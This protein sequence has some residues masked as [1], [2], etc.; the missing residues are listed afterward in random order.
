MSSPT[1][2]GASSIVNH[3][4]DIAKFLVDAFAEADSPGVDVSDPVTMRSG[5][6]YMSAEDF[7]LA[8]NPQLPQLLTKHVEKSEPLLTEDPRYSVLPIRHADM[9][10]VYERHLA[11]FWTA[12]EIVY[13]DD[14]P[15]WENKLTDDERFFI[16][17]ILAFFSQSDG[18]VIENLCVRFMAEV[19]PFE[20]KCY[21]GVQ[22]MVETIHS[23]VYALL[24]DTFIKD[25][26][27]KE[28][29]L[30]AI[31]TIPCVQDKGN[32]ALKWISDDAPF[33]KRLIA[34][35]IVE[36]IFFSGAFCSIYWLKNRGLMVKALGT[37]NEF[38]C[39]DE[40][41]HV[42][43][44]VLLYTKH[45][46]YKLPSEEVHEMFREAV[47]LETEFICVALPCRLIGMNN[48]LMEQYI[49]F[50]ADRLLSQ[51]GYE[52]VWGVA[53]P[54]DFMD[55]IAIHNKSN[56]FEGRATDYRRPLRDTEH[57]DLENLEMDDF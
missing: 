53:N 50:V 55:L 21:Y 35:S 33:A 54:F 52:K 46:V 14:V 45:I 5:I 4:P 43:F 49:Q 13:S 41:I 56:F 25:E 2:D 19:K 3:P 7:L 57:V 23:H 42:E 16:E 31:H 48:E 17:H 34:F 10:E 38:I 29:L 11:C 51:L 27:R 36:G 18:I 37:S 8:T 15:D 44:A 6:A 20:A 28:E 22:N 40:G 12:Q 9:F 24:I 26:A 30:D 1:I 32:W 47:A 39:R